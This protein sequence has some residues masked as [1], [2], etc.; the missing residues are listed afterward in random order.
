MLLR[1]VRFLFENRID[2]NKNKYLFKDFK[3]VS[4]S[5]DQFPYEY[6]DAKFKKKGDKTKGKLAGD[7]MEKKT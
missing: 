5:D 7:E 6:I 4:P 2:L 1:R 3:K